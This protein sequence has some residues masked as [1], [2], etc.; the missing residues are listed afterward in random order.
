MLNKNSAPQAKLGN[1][2]N[3]PHFH[4]DSLCDQLSLLKISRDRGDT[5]FVK[6]VLRIHKTTDEIAQVERDKSTAALDDSAAPPF[7]VFS[8]DQQTKR[9][10]CFKR[11]IDTDKKQ[12]TFVLPSQLGILAG[13]ET[14]SNNQVRVKHLTGSLKK[15]IISQQHEKHDQNLLFGDKYKPK[16]PDINPVKVNVGYVT[17]KKHNRNLILESVLGNQLI[18]SPD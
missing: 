7:E 4:F 2:F 11:Y 16:L 17:S 9:E 5:Y 1:R 6:N 3:E 14:R 13:Y 18:R 12:K 8:P 10:T 15:E